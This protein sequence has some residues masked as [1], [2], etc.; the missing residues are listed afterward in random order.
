MDVSND[1]C[2][3]WYFV[4]YFFNWNFI[5]LD[6]LLLILVNKLHISPQFD[7]N[8]SSQFD[9]LYK[10]LNMMA[11]HKFELFYPNLAILEDF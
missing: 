1:Y 7:L 5:L 3:F 11:I 4:Y 2:S 8:C 9:I 6:L 10:N